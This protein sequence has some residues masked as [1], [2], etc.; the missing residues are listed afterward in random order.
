[1]LSALFGED[2]ARL[3]P[4]VVLD[5]GV[6]A[7]TRG[8]A[9]PATLVTAV[10]VQHPLRRLCSHAALARRHRDANKSALLELLRQQMEHRRASAS[11]DPLGYFLH[12]LAPAFR[13]R[14]WGDER[15]PSYAA[16]PRPVRSDLSVRMAVEI[17]SLPIPVFP[18]P[19]LVVLGRAWQLVETTAPECRGRT[20]VVVGAGTLGL[21]G[22]C[23]S[24]W[25]IESEWLAQANNAIA[26]VAGRL[27]ALSDS[28]PE[29]PDLAPERE[30][31]ASRGSIESGDLLLIAGAPPL[32]AH[33]LPSHYNSTRGRQS[34]RDLAV[35]APLELPPRLGSV[36]VYE[37][38]RDGRWGWLSLPNGLCLG[39]GAPS[40]IPDEPGLNLAAYLRW[41]AIRLAANGRFHE[42]D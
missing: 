6:Y 31:L 4:L 12:Y 28:E 14:D 20:H 24:A 27:A 36:A 42:R 11:A 16:P 8:E 18:C 2:L 41:A 7:K 29:W 32:L 9:G 13:E 21:T 3:Q 39:P 22:G 17:A 5:D 19:S 10:G 34:E 30:R 15:S 1:V 25:S 35:A 37:R 38:A 40:M 23:R 26:L 33:V